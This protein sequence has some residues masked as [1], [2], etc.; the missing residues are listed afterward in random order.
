MIK[1]VQLTKD[2]T[3]S[4]P[5]GRACNMWDVY[6][7]DPLVTKVAHYGFLKEAINPRRKW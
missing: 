1:R 2:W 7:I 3:F 4:D 6:W 5:W